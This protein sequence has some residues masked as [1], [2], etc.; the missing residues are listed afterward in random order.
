MWKHP[1]TAFG[2]LALKDTI[3]ALSEAKGHLAQSVATW[4]MIARQGG[5]LQ[6]RSL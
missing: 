4:N 3:R 5:A 2:N 1:K 6:S